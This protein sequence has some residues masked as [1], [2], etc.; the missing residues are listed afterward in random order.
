MKKV[1]IGL[2]RP[3]PIS[4]SIYGDI[5]QD[6]NF[7]TLKG[8]I[9]L[10]GVLEPLVITG[11]YFIISGVR[12][13]FASQQLGLQEIPVVFSPFSQEQVDEYMV[14]SHQQQRVKSAVQILREIE[15]ITKK[16]DLKQ[17]KNPKKPFGYSREKRKR[18]VDQSHIPFNIQSTQRIQKDVESCSW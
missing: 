9:D 13:F 16:Y 15:I 8:S 3:N 5:D 7:L 2:L 18:R 11:D 14:I 10:E 6:E 4:F 1:S 17:G 12:R